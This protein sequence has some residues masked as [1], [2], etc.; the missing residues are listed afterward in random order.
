MDLEVKRRTTQMTCVDFG[1]G[2]HDR[3]SFLTGS[4]YPSGNGSVAT[5]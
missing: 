5:S 2:G 1:I 3:T 4:H